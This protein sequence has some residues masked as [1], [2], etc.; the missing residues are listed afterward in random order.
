MRYSLIILLETGPEAVTI[1][2]RRRFR[3]Y[4]ISRGRKRKG[5][6]DGGEEMT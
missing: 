5:K 2:R 1:P 4:A 3:G 6:G